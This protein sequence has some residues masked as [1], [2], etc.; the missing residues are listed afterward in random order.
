[1]NSPLQLAKR[2]NPILQFDFGERETEKSKAKFSPSGKWKWKNRVYN[3]PFLHPS[4][5]DKVMEHGFQLQGFGSSGKY[6]GFSFTSFD[7]FGSDEK[8]KEIHYLNS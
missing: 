8:I 1:M 2:R 6:F 5:Q 3:A 7:I 4:S